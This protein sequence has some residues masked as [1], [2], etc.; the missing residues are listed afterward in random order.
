MNRLAALLVVIAGG[1]CTVSYPNST[2]GL[3]D[4][5]ACMI[6]PPVAYPTTPPSFAV[7]GMATVTLP[8]KLAAYSIVS[9]GVGSYTLSWTNASDDATC[10]TGLITGIDAFTMVGG[11]SGHETVGVLSPTQ[12]G[13]AG[14]PGTTTEGISFFEEVDPIIVDVQIGGMAT[15]NIYYIAGSD[16]VD[17]PA[18]VDPAAF[19]SP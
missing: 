1:G 9:N 19:H 5:S 11:V 13:F 10:F 2:S 3:P 12:L 8:D 6:P 4:A 14:A 17:A 15:G 16:G 7:L 18:G